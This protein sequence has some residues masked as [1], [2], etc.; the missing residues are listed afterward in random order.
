MTNYELIKEAS[1]E[2]KKHKKHLLV[3]GLGAAAGAYG[4]L[5]GTKALL[6]KVKATGAIKRTG[7]KGVGALAGATLGYKGTKAIIKKI[8]KAREQ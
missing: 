1:E 3:R 7:L 4:G 8:Q 5:K 6:N 2:V